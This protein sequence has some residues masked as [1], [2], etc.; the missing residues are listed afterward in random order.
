MG[1][2]GEPDEKLPLYTYSIYSID[3]VA[4]K[5]VPT[6]SVK[7]NIKNLQLVDKLKMIDVSTIGGR[8]KY[9]RVLNRLS[10]DRLSEL[11]GFSVSKIWDFEE[12]RSFCLLEFCQA[13]ADVL[14]IDLSLI[15]DEYTLFLNSGYIQ[16]IS[17]AREELKIS[18]SK[19][20]VLYGIPP[21]VLL[22]WV[23]AKCVP[24]RASFEKYIKDNPLFYSF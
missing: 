4:K 20:A 5:L 6:L 8:V 13:V 19:M 23:Q 3:V 10:V 14:K 9:Y 11:I 22:N 7:I 1:L 16:R 18:Y 17:K 2:D 12:C 24:S 15:C 21:S